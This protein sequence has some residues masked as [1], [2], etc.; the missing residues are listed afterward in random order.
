MTFAGLVSDPRVLQNLGWAYIAMIL[1]QFLINIGF[2]VGM[3]LRAYKEKKEKKKR[4]KIRIQ[5]KKQK[6]Q[7]QQLLTQT[8]LLKSRRKEEQVLMRFEQQA[9][10]LGN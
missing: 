2:V 7:E 9:P 10:Y 3:S 6:S 4:R 1:I 8:T 5:L